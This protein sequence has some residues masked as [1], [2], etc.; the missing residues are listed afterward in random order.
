MVALSRVQLLLRAHALTRPSRGSHRR[1]YSTD[2][3]VLA[4]AFSAKASPAAA[5][6]QA[7]GWCPSP[8]RVGR[9]RRRSGAASSS[10]NLRQSELLSA[11]CEICFTFVCAFHLIFELVCVAVASVED[12]KKDVLVALSQIIDPDFG[13]DIVSC[14][15]VKDL[16]ISEA[17]EEVKL[18][19]TC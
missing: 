17:L 2:F 15:F 6:A 11:N 10:G 8:R 9:L 5:V 13:T 18:K 19:D 4:G 14:G 3:M 12:A 7:H 16:E 1:A